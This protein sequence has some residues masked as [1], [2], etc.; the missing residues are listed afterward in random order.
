MKRIDRTGETYG[1]LT[2][3]EHVPNAPGAKD[4]NARWL[5][6]CVC[7]TTKVVYGQDLKK[8]KVVSCGCWNQEKRTK[9]GMSH[10]HVH[11]V[12][13]AMRDRCRNPN[14]LAFKNYG[15]RGI[16][17]CDR[18]D[19]FS[20]FLAD[21]GD[22]PEGF[23]LDRIDNNGNYEPSNCR[24]L[25][26]QKNLNNKRTNRFLELRGETHTIA[27]WSRITGLS[28]LTIRQRL[29]YGWTVERTLTEPLKST[30]FKEQ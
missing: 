2:V 26:R 24:W 23:D 6:R 30:Q 14:N 1:R 3:I 22:R 5:C 27:E 7:G 28:W 20:D 17:V 16:K 11:K 19:S 15:G 10:T 25:S 8:G 4:T 9:H 12:W 29:R 13:I 18:W 21:M